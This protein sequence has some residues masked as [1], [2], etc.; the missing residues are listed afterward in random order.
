MGTLPPTS[1][2][3][4][5]ALLQLMVAMWDFRDWSSVDCLMPYQSHCEAPIGPDPQFQPT[6]R[7]PSTPFL[8][9]RLFQFPHPNS[10]QLCFSPLT[11]TARHHPAC[12]PC[13]ETTLACMPSLLATAPGEI[14]VAQKNHAGFRFFLRQQFHCTQ[15]SLVN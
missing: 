11:P 14:S 6:P 9:G 5:T 4:A 10:L 12:D 7:R 1:T 2:S 8:F 15:G 13:G 3:V